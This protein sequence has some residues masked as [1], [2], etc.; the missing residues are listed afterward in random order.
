MHFS[1]WS[2]QNWFKLIILTLFASSF[3]IPIQ[4]LKA[5]TYKSFIVEKVIGSDK[6]LITDGLSHY[7]TTYSFFGC[8]S[9]DFYSGKI[10]YI[11]TYFSPSLFNK[12]LVEGIGDT[13]TCDISN[14][15]DLNL[16]K[17]YVDSVIDSKDNIIVIDKYGT[18]YLVE[19]GIGCL[20]MWR[21]EGKN[22]DVDIGGSF[23]DGVGDRIY[24]FDS[25]DDCKVWDA[26]ELSSGSNAPA[27]PLPS[28]NPVPAFSCPA[29]SYSNGDKCIC[30]S[31][32]ITNSAKTGCVLA[33]APTPLVCDTGFL[34]RNGQCISYTQD[35][36][37]TFGSNVIGSLGSDSNSNCN[38]ASGYQ[39]NNIQTA[40]V[41]II[42][43]PQPTLVPIPA[44]NVPPTVSAPKETFVLDNSKLKNYKPVL[45]GEINTT[46]ALRK[47][48]S[49][50][51]CD[52]L[53]Y[54]IE[55]MPVEILGD[56]NNGE[57]YKITVIDTQQNGWMHSSIVNKITLQE[58]N[59]NV[60][61]KSTASEKTQ[62]DVSWYK[63]LFGFFSNL[64]K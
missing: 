46:A 16:K 4:Q 6:L 50:S 41:K 61:E 36:I 7:L 28:Y 59:S 63:K 57:W 22:I 5:A 43:P 32:Y 21:Y 23:L 40:C 18:K 1:N 10:I 3:L 29:N 14:S 39:W 52:V 15:E 8:S 12:I 17:Y 20:S 27:Y 58:N 45:S 37:N 24:L 53:R 62:K 49:T 30:V 47:C 56:Y 54:Y 33:P 35:C 19:Y 38:C 55:G 26:D 64:F 9:W 11:D 31:G 51:D 44:Q 34:V 2:K 48:P 13:K 25:D 60:P 42:T